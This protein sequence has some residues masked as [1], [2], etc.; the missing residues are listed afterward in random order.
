MS[1]Q[2]GKSKKRSK[3]CALRGRGSSL[4]LMVEWHSLTQRLKY[5]DLGDQQK[6][7]KLQ[8]ERKEAGTQRG[9]MEKMR[10]AQTQLVE[11]NKSLVQGLVSIGRKK[12][13]HFVFKLKTRM[14]LLVQLGKR[15][16][17]G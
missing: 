8:R 11:E 9:N 16:N 14:E 3:P 4:W 12:D 15:E 1:V 13:G 6:T 7:N 5:A 10:T 2:S 17:R